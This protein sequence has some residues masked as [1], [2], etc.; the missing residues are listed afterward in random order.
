MAGMAEGPAARGTL[1]TAP[2]NALCFV[3]SNAQ[4]MPV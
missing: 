2:H 1:T 4:G 3:P